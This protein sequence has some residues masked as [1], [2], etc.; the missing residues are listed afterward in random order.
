MATGDLSHLESLGESEIWW[1]DKSPLFEAHGYRLRPRYRPGWTPSWK[2]KPIFAVL[3]AEDALDLHAR[4]GVI[5][6]T[7]ISDGKLIYL[8]KIRVD[9]D[10][11]E[12]LRFLSSPEMVQDPHNHCVRLL[13]IIYD[14]DEIGFCF[15]VMPYL[16]WIDCP[17]FEYVEDMLECGEQILEGLVFL[18]DHGV[19]HRDC[20]YK[21]IMMDATAM[22]PKGFHPIREGFLPDNS[23]QAPVLHRIDVPIK[24]YFIDFGIS[25]RFS[26]NQQPRL[27]LGTQGLD[28][29]VPELSDTVPY[30]PFRTDVFIIG[31]LFQQQFLQR[32]SNAR[33]LSSLVMRM[34]SKDP[35]RRPDAAEALREW[36]AIRRRVYRPQRFWRLRPLEESW[37]A[38]LFYEV[39][40]GP[41]L[42]QHG[43]GLR[44]RYN[45]GWIPSWRNRPDSTEAWV[46]SE[47]GYRLPYVNSGLVI[48]AIR[49]ADNSLVCIKKVLTNSEEL[50]LSTYLSSKNLRGLINNHCVPVLEVLQHPD[51]S[52]A[53]LLPVMPSLRPLNSPAFETVE[54]VVECGEQILEGLVF[55]HQYDIAQRD[56]AFK[57]IMLDAKALYPRGFDPVLRDWGPDTS[58]LA[59]VLSRAGALVKY[60]FMD[61]GISTK[62]APETTDKTVRGKKGLDKTVPELSDDVGYCPFKVDV[63][64]LGNLF[65]QRF[66]NM[67]QNVPISKLES[68]VRTMTETDPAA[69]PDAEECLRQWKALRKS[70]P[71]FSR[72]W[73]LCP[74]DKR[75]LVSVVHDLF[76]T[77]CMFYRSSTIKYVVVVGALSFVVPLLS[78]PRSL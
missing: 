77:L 46:N 75:L 56:R 34:V 45:A 5:D 9:S 35:T 21:N 18:H 52:A 28:D 41:F 31:N 11:L 4:A 59:P 37:L 49:K 22:Y 48:D 24:Y 70:T 12:L 10:E 65:R 38:T 53:S 58:S 33:M 47:D 42:Q 14:P 25:T 27:V 61:F 71:K 15:V 30:D 19:A 13:D 20:A 66:I 74:R 51:D 7:R 73:R 78:T 55:L 17:P 43:Y 67:Y 36:K 68:L 1:R 32:F 57:N 3:Y 6:A 60:Y 69:R 63:Y 39:H 8:K 44:P 23:G 72:I 40:A 2:G 54:D 50:R 16:R 76:Y 62:F 29:E 64:I 26:V